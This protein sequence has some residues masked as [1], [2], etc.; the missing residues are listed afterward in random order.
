MVTERCKQ[1]LKFIAKLLVTVILLLWVFS[2]IDLTQFSQILKKARWSFLWIVWGLTI[3]AYWILSIKMRLILKKQDCH[4]DTG[5]LFGASAITALY[6]MILPGVL[7]APVKWYVIRQHTGKGSNVFSSMVYNQF[8]VL[9]FTSASALVALIVTNPTGNWHLPAIC[10]AILIF[11]IAVSLSLLNRTLGPKLTSYLSHII[12]PLP[13]SFRS[14]AGKILSQLSVFQTASWAFHFKVV[15]LNF[16]SIT[17]VSTTIYIF[18]AK[19][20]RIDVPVGVFIWLCAVIFILGRLPISIANLGVREVTLVG[21]L[22]LYGV[23][24]PSAFLMSMIIFSNRILMAIIGVIF[25]LYWTMRR[26][27][28]RDKSRG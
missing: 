10:L 22:A 9:I 21:T 28:P 15:L 20:A 23:D 16:M 11:L 18:A 17:I 19:A 3:V 12:E 1:I 14:T 5:T 24:A 13:A 8:S 27:E 25:Q 2:R 26:S 4:A 7:D 6:S